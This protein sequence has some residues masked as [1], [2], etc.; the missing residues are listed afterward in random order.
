MKY[1]KKMFELQRTTDTGNFMDYKEDDI[2]VSVTTIER[3]DKILLTKE[4]KYKV[5]KLYKTV[6]DKFLNNP[7]MRVDVED[8]ETG[9]ITRGWRSDQ[10]KKKADFISKKYRL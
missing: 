8:L 6:E 5:I 9:E 4:R 3:G 7:W 10:F 2:V 1:L